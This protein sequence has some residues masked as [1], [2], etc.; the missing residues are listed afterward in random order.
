MSMVYCPNCGLGM[1]GDAEISY[2]LRCAH[3]FAAL[4]WR[5]ANRRKR[6]DDRRRAYPF[7]VGRQTT[8]RDISHG[9]TTGGPFHR[10]PGIAIERRQEQGGGIKK[11]GIPRIIAEIRYRHWRNQ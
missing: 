1:S 7:C 11:E 9:A 6:M 4:V 5:L 10:I 2:C 8:Y 3:P